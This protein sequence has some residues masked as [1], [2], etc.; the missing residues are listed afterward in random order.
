MTS[1]SYKQC[2]EMA[3][4]MPQVERHPPRDLL[5]LLSRTIASAALAVVVL[6]G[7]S[8]R[9]AEYVTVAWLVS[10]I[11]PAY[12]QFQSISCSAVPTSCPVFSITA[13]GGLTAQ[14]DVYAFAQRTLRGDGYVVA[15]VAG[16]SGVTS[17]L[18]G[19]SIR[20]SLTPGAAQISLLQTAGGGLVVRKRLQANAPVY[21]SSVTAVSRTAWLRL[22]RK[23]QTISLAQSA[24][25]TQWASIPGATLDLPETAYAGLAV[26]SQR[27]DAMATATLSH[28][29]MVSLSTLPAGWTQG[30]SRRFGVEPGAIFPADLDHFAVGD[31]HAVLGGH[32]VRVSTGGRRRRDRRPHGRSEPGHRACRPDGARHAGLR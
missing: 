23:G 13:A 5:E 28:V 20:G 27:P 18:A 12:P 29:Q 2:L 30:R 3:Q 24:D 31:G 8:L 9:S 14:E 6:G 11:G 32:L 17:A 10:S 26:S 16:I 22:E 1:K 4:A 25:G 15:R 19:L 7:V 21:Q